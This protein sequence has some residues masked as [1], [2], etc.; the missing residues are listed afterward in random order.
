MLAGIGIG[1]YLARAQRKNYAPVVKTP[2]SLKPTPNGKTSLP[3][4]KKD[5][6]VKQKED[7]PGVIR[8]MKNDKGFG[9]IT[10]NGN[11]EIF[12][13]IKN[14]KNTTKPPRPGMKVLFNISEDDQKRGKT[15]AI[16]L[17]LVE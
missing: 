11:N 13:H 10:F 14:W 12:F 17:R 4:E 15:A 9:F 7:I 1:L 3:E 16:N 5:P 8:L 6:Q 2:G